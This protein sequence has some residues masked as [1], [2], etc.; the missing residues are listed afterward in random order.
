MSE[1]SHVEAVELDHSP[2]SVDMNSEA[3]G[4]FPFHAFEFDDPSKTAAPVLTVISPWGFEVVGDLT[5]GDDLNVAGDADVDGDLDVGG[6]A[7][8]TGALSVTGVA[9]GVPPAG[10]V[11]PYAGATAPGGYLL[12]DGSAVSR[13]TYA[14]LFAVIGETFGAGDSSTTFNVPD[15]REA[16]PVGI[17]TRA[18]GVTAHDAFTRAQ[19]KDDQLQGHYHT[20]NYSS[21]STNAASGAA[22]IAANSS[23]DEDGHVKAAAT[24]GTNG[25]PRTGAVTRGK[26]L[27]LNFIIKT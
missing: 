25:A 3:I 9:T 26:G 8:I 11:L 12:C 5:V 10:V 4:K 2:G 21:F 13:S 18:S 24:D 15:M 17:G 1:P 19:F 22:R 23:G 20:F 16:V 27:G 14:A 7:A 6:D